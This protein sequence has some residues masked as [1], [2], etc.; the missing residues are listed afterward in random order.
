MKDGNNNTLILA[1][2][3]NHQSAVELLVKNGADVNITGNN[4]M[5]PLMFAIFKRN[6]D[7]VKYLLDNGADVNKKD[8]DGTTA[9]MMGHW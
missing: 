9:L 8:N 2:H 1:V 3:G 5:T 7:I 4:G 6:K